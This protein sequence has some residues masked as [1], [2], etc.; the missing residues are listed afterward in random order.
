MNALPGR[1][2]APPSSGTEP[3]APPVAWGVIGR[4]LARTLTCDLPRTLAHHRVDRRQSTRTRI[5]AGH[6]RG[7]GRAEP[8]VAP[9]RGGS[10]QPPSSAEAPMVA[11]VE[12]NR[13]VNASMR[14]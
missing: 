2:S 3:D 12:L 13:A 4:N 5:A 7:A 10:R 6:S 8:R 1:S 11:D 14:P 9:S